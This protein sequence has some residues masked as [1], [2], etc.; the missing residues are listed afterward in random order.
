MRNSERSFSY[1]VFVLLLPNI[2]P[3]FDPILCCES[4][5]EGTMSDTLPTKSRLRKLSRVVAA[6][7]LLL[8]AILMAP[9]LL[10][11]PLARL[12]LRQVF[13][14][15]T[16]SVGSAVLS[17]SGTLILRKLELH[18]TGALAQQPLITAREV[19]VEFRWIELLSLRTR[20]LHAKDVAVYA[21]SN[22]SSQ[23]SLL[24]LIFR[25][26]LYDPAAEFDHGTLSLWIDTL[27]AQG[28][29]H[30]EPVKGFGSAS[31]NLPLVL[32]MTASGDR[33]APS[34]QFRM[35]IGETQP[36]PDKISEKP[37]MT[38]PDLAS[39][40]GTAFGLRA[41]V[42]TQP[43]AGGTSRVVYR[44]VARHAALMI[45]ADILRRYVT[46]L[47]PELQGH[48]ETSLG[49]LWVTGE[50]NQQKS[51]ES[52]QLSG[53]LRFA[54]LRVHLPGNSPVTLSLDG[55]DGAARIDTP[56]PPGPG[57]A[58]TI[59]RLQ[60]RNATAS[61]EA[62]VLHRHAPK[63]P[64]A[65]HGPLD[66]NF[67]AL[68]ATGLIAAEP[69]DM[70]KFSGNIR[71]Q[72]LSVSVR[73]PA[74]G[75]PAFTLERLTVAGRVESRLDRWIPATLKVR[76][77]V[78]QWAALTY[79][80]NAVNNLDMSWRI[81]NHM[82]MADHCAAQIFGGHLS[83][84]LAWDL[85]TSALPRCDFQL[86]SIN[87]H[88]ALANL[89]PEHIDAEG[90]ASGLLHLALSPESDL[91]GSVDLTFDGPG[92]LRI[93]EVEEIKRMLVGNFG[94]DLA[95]LAM[96]DLKQYPFQEGSLYLESVSEN[97]QLKIKFVR[98]P[99]TEADVKPPHKEIINGTEVW[100]GSLVVPTIDMTI[101]ITGKSLAE[102]LS[103]VGGVHLLSEAANEQ[104]GK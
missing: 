29:M 23:L 33:A 62:D 63:L 69:E 2:L 36:L 37:S 73:S 80:N 25:P 18:D 22:D 52:R 40:V 99:R 64:V 74:G 78:M 53:N 104:P 101:P 56:L 38:V 7:L 44:L 82:L 47:P 21:R 49:N 72:D 4:V 32:H 71:L 67:A 17:P 35:T 43:A 68:D 95:N 70:L 90:E 9:F 41:E 57:T 46:K 81:D 77:G 102:I 27:N 3:R 20:Q 8:V 34:R 65:L 87:I 86:K 88:E 75:K 42:D 61:I 28:I 93:G 14:A 6:L 84:S 79:S 76:D 83:G 58:I 13:P 103:L 45:E 19:E 39:R 54:G 96:H 94:L 60:A 85:I 51:V 100:V 50:V 26:S 15:H 31:A 30:L 24:A 92:I 55:M 10:T 12:V 11:T 48:I 66:T 59:E 98:Q 1:R 5:S 16:P 91:F 89:S 97:S